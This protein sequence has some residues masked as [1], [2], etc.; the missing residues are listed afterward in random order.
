MRI[1]EGFAF[2]IL[3]GRKNNAFGL[4]RS[5]T[6]TCPIR[7]RSV[8]IKSNL[9]PGGYI[10]ASERIGESIWCILVLWNG[11]TFFLEERQQIFE[12]HFKV[13]KPGGLTVVWVP[14]RWGI[15]F[16][17][18]RTIRQWFN[19]KNC[20]IDEIPFTKEELLGRAK[21][22]GF[23]HCAIFGGT[24]MGDDFNLHL[25]NFKKRMGKIRPFMNSDQAKNEVIKA[26]CNNRTP[27]MFYEKF[28]SYSLVLIGYKE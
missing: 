12:S 25:Y 11:W 14:N 19:R 2:V 6:P 16:H 8:R 18:G 21:Q 7:C 28:F 4:Q 26:L 24:S 9:A 3:H 23:L 22:S 13:L 10:I 15:F 1:R 20:R 17:A 27:Q 5:P